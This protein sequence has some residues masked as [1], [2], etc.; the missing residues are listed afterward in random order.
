MHLSIGEI[1]MV[2]AIAAL[3]YFLHR[4]WMKSLINNSAIPKI[5]GIKFSIIIIL[6][7]T[8]FFVS[9]KIVYA[10]ADLEEQSTII[11]HADKIPFY[12][13]VTI[14]KFANHYFS[15]QPKNKG[16]LYNASNAMDSPLR[17]DS[18][19]L[20]IEN[21]NRLNI[22][23][24]IIDSW[25]YD[26]FSPVVSPKIW[27]YAKDA[28]V[29]NHHISGGN[30][31][32]IGLFS[33]FYGIYG[34]YWPSILTSRT[35]PILLETLRDENYKNYI[36]SSA[37]L[38]FPEFRQTIFVNHHNEIQDAF[39]GKSPWVRD[40]QLTD[41]MLKVLEEPPT[42]PMFAMLF[43]DGAH[44]NYDYPLDQEPFKPSTRKFYYCSN[45]EPEKKKLI[46]NRYKNSVHHVDFQIGRVL[47]KL[48]ESNIYNNTIVLITGDHGEE[49]YDYNHWGHFSS[50]SKSQVHV[51]LIIKAP[52]KE[53][54][55]YN[56]ETTSHIDLP[57]TILELLGS[58][59]NPKKFSLGHS[60]FS[61]KR[62]SAVACGWDT[63]AFIEP[64]QTVVYGVQPYN[65]NL[66][67]KYDRNY[68]Y[69]E[70]CK[71]L[72]SQAS[73]NLLEELGRFR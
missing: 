18:N 1:L 53:A 6:I 50:F 70:E 19:P 24:I 20:K 45:D 31:T 10:W 9:E 34:S 52:G 73:I 42:R 55:V 16:S 38:N 46:I 59:T 12:Q 33:M 43:Y 40:K 63:C 57:A 68:N 7:S 4:Q 23:W 13:P 39:T 25:R 44:S 41:T 37:S 71:G 8:L 14:K 2:I 47:S 48:K 67:E 26:A 61:N 15:Y 3:I 65:A 49:F 54:L 30:N 69:C 5:I 11:R 36:L 56:T 35:P 32:R 51:P 17:Y 58:K 62:N 22:I 29:F 66:L 72:T 60:I 21:K 27:N 28:Q 64:E